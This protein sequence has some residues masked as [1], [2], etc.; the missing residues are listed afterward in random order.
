MDK[1]LLIVGAGSYAVVAF[2][3]AE[4]IGCFKKIA[5]VDDERKATPNGIEVVGKI[6]DIDNLSTQYNKIIVALDNAKE[7]ISLLK[8]IREETTYQIIS[9]VS[10]RAYVAHSAEIM[11]GCIIEPMA[12]IH[13]GCVICIGCIISAGAVVNHTTICCDGVC[14]ECNSTI[15]EGCI[16]PIGQRIQKGTVYNQK[17]N[18]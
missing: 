14:V 11:A 1:N 2:E 17:N 3:I 12:V 6:K 10:P 13:T 18:K 9:L 7:R 5:F 16:V 8:R 15:S 4:D